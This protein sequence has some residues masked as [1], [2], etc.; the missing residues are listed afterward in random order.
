MTLNTPIMNHTGINM[1]TFKS[2]ITEHKIA[3]SNEPNML[4][5]HLKYHAAGMI[6]HHNDRGKIH[7]LDG[8]AQVYDSRKQRIKS[9]YRDG[10]E[11]G[12]QYP[13]SLHPQGTL[14]YWKHT[15]NA[16]HGDLGQ[17]IPKEEFEKIFPDPDR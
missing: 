14:R 10:V 12:G 6:T 8:P 13:V 15:P 16:P 3:L 11:I 5:T 17:D 9:W 2:F 7:R 1:K 4:D